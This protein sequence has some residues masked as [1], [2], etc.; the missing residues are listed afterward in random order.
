MNKFK[1]T[2]YITNYNYG[3]FISRAIDSVLKQTMQNFELIIIDDGSTDNS[4][5]IIERYKTTPNIRII[6]QKNLGLNQSNNVALELANGEYLVR[7]DA[8]DYFSETALET[9][10]RCLDKDPKAGL[11]FPNYYLVDESDQ[12]LYEV[13]RH[14]FSSDV[15]LFDQ[16]AHGAC[17]MVRVSFLKKVGGYFSDFKC[18]DG[19]DLWIKFI[20]KFK[21]VNVNRSLFYY[22]QH[23]HNL[24]KNE[25]FLLNTRALI[26]KK[27]VEVNQLSLPKTIGII[28]IRS[29]NSSRLLFTEVNGKSLLE[30]KIDAALKSELIKGV[31]IVSSDLEVD[32]YIKSKYNDDR[33]VFIE[34]PEGFAKYG[35]SLYESIG[36]VFNNPVIKRNYERFD[37]FVLLALEFPFV[38]GLEID[39]II[40]SSVIYNTDCVISVRI[41]NYTLYNHNGNTLVP[42]DQSGTS[43]YE[44]DLFYFSAGGMTFSFYDNLEKNKKL[45]SGKVG[46]VLVDQIGGMEMRTQLDLKIANEMSCI[47]NGAM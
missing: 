15:T 35:A 12:I 18:Q 37:A 38:N 16:P 24:T 17:T 45:P 33:L 11:V 46:H 22:R 14:D 21:V 47:V 10:S 32:K 28:P 36:L 43:K 23:G 25:T 2:V 7:L 27:F 13:K 9:L 6:Y 19:Y 20:S 29:L 34:R 41:S 3:R 4:K 40:R 39:N 8:D 5:E 1:V 42:V 44:R 30:L 31:A 26:N